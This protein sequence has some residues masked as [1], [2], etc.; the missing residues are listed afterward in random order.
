MRAAARALTEW[1]TPHIRTL[2]SGSLAR[3]S[4]TFCATKCFFLVLVLLAS[5]EDPRL[6]G[7][8]MAAASVPSTAALPRPGTRPL[9]SP[10]G[11]GSRI[12]PAASPRRR[13]PLRPR[14][15]SAP[16]RSPCPLCPAGDRGCAARAGTASWILRPPRLRAQPAAGPGAP[17]A[18]S[19]LGAGVMT[20]GAGC[21]LPRRRQ[22]GR[23][24]SWDR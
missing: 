15:R 6:P 5:T 19:A 1:F 23:G 24:R 22:A 10:A 17:R 2:S 14:A 8:A 18:A 3:K 11:G 13:A 16:Q 9:Y 7:V 21:Q 12:P 4:F 20:Q